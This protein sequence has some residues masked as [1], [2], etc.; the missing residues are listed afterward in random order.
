MLRNAH[1]HLS[2]PDY[3]KSLAQLKNL[4]YWENMAKD[5]ET[6]VKSCDTCQRTK[7]RTTAM[8]GLLRQLAVP[9]RPGQ[10]I[11]MDFISMGCRSYDPTTKQT[12]D[13]VFVITDRLTRIC[14]FIPCT[15][16]LDAAGAAHLFIANWYK[17]FGVPDEIISDRDSKFTSEYWTALCKQLGIERKLSSAYHPQTDGATERVN[18]TMLQMLT[19][20]LL[21][22]PQHEWAQKLPEIEFNYNARVHDTIGMA[23]FQAA[24]G[25]IPSFGDYAFSATNPRTIKERIESAL[26]KSKRKRQTIEEQA[27]KKRKIAQQYKVGDHVLI[28]T[29]DIRKT[30]PLKNI[31][32]KLQSRYQGPYPIIEVLNKDVYRVKLPERSK[33]HNVF[34]TS[35]L[36]PYIF[37]QRGK[38]PERDEVP[39]RPGPVDPDEPNHFEVEKVVAHD[40]NGRRP[41]RLRY[42]VLWEGYPPTEAT[43]EPAYIISEDAPRLVSEYLKTLSRKARA[44]LEA[45]LKRN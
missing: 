12:Y 27:N 4:C 41:H 35:L 6:Y 11:A 19:S 20:S 32:K 38:Y 39:L 26:S 30:D 45:E 14:V 5:L 8:P 29:R 21:R 10:S 17:R 40:M 7:M 16:E 15:K 36:R 9:T 22:K 25:Y 37:T 24:Y 1:D 23:P 44:E 31:S 18:R 33:L 28:D 43:W 13:S 3:K 42:K 34:H 2:H